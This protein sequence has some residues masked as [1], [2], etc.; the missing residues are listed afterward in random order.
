MRHTAQAQ[1]KVLHSNI[2]LKCHDML[3]F[4]LLSPGCNGQKAAPSPTSQCRQQQAQPAACR[5]SSTPGCAAQPLALLQTGCYDQV[6]RIKE[7][8]FEFPLRVALAEL[9]FCIVPASHISLCLPLRTAIRNAS[10]VLFPTAFFIHLIDNLPS[11][12]H[13]LVH[14]SLAHKS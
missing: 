8:G 11:L 10:P 4:K 2:H 14:A 6:L 9:G 3:A 1:C 13:N 5:W 12:I 7:T